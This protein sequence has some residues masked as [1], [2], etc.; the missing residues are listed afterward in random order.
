MSRKTPTSSRFE[1]S[2]LTFAYSPHA[3]ASM[4]STFSKE[5]SAMKV[6]VLT[7]NRCMPCGFG[8]EPTVSVQVHVERTAHVPEMETYLTIAG[9]SFPIGT[10]ELSITHSTAASPE[11]VFQLGL[12]SS[13]IRYTYPSSHPIHSS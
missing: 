6:P 9:A 7:T 1:F 11:S 13:C 5:P 4:A 10:Q 12:D 3:P 8:S 2:I